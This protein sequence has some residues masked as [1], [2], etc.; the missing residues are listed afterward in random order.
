[1]LIALGHPQ[2]PTPIRTD[3]STASSFANSA[4]TPKRSK[5]WD[6]RYHWLQDRVKSKDFYIYW[7][8]GKINRA[9]YHTKHFSPSYHQEQRKHYILQGHLLTQKM[10][11]VNTFSHHKMFMPVRVCLSP[12]TGIKPRSLQ[13]YNQTV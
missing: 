3:N 7:D 12:R 2:P 6:M 5:S 10:K 9:D 4:Y 13:D 8:K 11:N 1:M